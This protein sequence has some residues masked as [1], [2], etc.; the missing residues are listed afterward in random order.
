MAFSE[1]II[2]GVEFQLE[3]TLPHG[4]VNLRLFGAALTI[5]MAAWRQ[6]SADTRAP[7]QPGGAAPG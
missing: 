6:L 3:V 2:S 7:T 1:T 4:G 5:S